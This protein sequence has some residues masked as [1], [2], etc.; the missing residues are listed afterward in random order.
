MIDRTWR[1]VLGVGIAAGIAAIV[2]SLLGGSHLQWKAGDAG[3]NIDL[4][5]GAG[6]GF[7]SGVL[8]TVSVICLLLGS[9]FFAASGRSMLPAQIPAEA[10]T[11]TPGFLEF[12]R[13]LHRS[14]TDVWLGGVCGGLGANS[15]VPTWVWRAVFLLLIFCFGTGVA[16][17]VILWICIPEEV[18]APP[19]AA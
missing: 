11:G 10:N 6:G 3:M 14:K 7:P 18:T 17:Y 15:P 8:G 13:K 5:I 9:A 4:R 2:L 1:I 16:A 19:K 12:L